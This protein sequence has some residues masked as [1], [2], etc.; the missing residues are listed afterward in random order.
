MAGWNL[1][2]GIC[3]AEHVTEN[4]FWVIINNVFS[5]KLIKQQAINLDFLRP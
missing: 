3:N 5:S 2:K 1:D 4:E